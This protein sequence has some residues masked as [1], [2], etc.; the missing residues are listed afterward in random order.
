MIEALDRFRSSSNLRAWAD[1]DLLIKAVAR[2]S[3]PD[4]WAVV[5]QREPDPCYGPGDFAELTPGA[6]RHCASEMSGRAC[7]NRL[8]LVRGLTDWRYA[9]GQRLRPLRTCP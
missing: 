8:Y 7:V 4:R 5:P 9:P 2:G 1:D 6:L 3:T